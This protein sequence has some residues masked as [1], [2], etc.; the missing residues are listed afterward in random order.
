MLNPPLGL[1]VF[2][3]F[4][5]V[6]PELASRRVLPLMPLQCVA[7]RVDGTWTRSK[8]RLTCHHRV[9]SA[10]DVAAI[11]LTLLT[12]S[13]FREKLFRSQDRPALRLASSARRSRPCLRTLDSTRAPSALL[14][15]PGCSPPRNRMTSDAFRL[16]PVALSCLD[17]DQVGALRSLAGNV[18]VRC[19]SGEQRHLRAALSRTAIDPFPAAT[20][21]DTQARARSGCRCRHHGGLNLTASSS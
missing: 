16:L 2:R 15:R 9:S 3:G 18:R 17:P 5:L 10:P 4:P 14:V 11:L 19:S 13:R 7:S 21:P 12:A 1:T 8:E 6:A 20:R